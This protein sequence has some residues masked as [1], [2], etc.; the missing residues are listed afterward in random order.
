MTKLHFKVEIPQKL[1]SLLENPTPFISATM[2]QADKLALTLLQESIKTN[3]PRRTGA[4]SRSIHID[5]AE[6]TVQTNLVYSRAIELGHYAEPRGKF[7]HFVDGGKDVFLR[8]TRSKKQPY[9]FKSINQN[10]LQVLEIYDDTFKKLM[11]NLHP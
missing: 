8:F 1:R 5:L 7:L 3:A 9:F 10:R 4:L 2:K 11:N 6:R